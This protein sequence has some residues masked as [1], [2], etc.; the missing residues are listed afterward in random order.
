[1]RCFSEP[2][3]HKQ[4]QLF[5][6]EA[7]SIATD[8]CRG[9][10]MLGNS[11]PVVWTYMSELGGP[12]PGPFGCKVGIQKIKETMMGA[13]FVHRRCWLLLMFL[14]CFMFWDSALLYSQVGLEL[15]RVAQGDLKLVSILLP[16]AP[17]VGTA[18]ASHIWL[19]IA[20]KQECLG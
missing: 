10:W 16:Q 14:I 4:I 6:E 12:S 15:T 1:M 18:G 5:R 11:H 20:Y 7:H 19:Q 17:S 13:L 9:L 2:E 3:S 8:L